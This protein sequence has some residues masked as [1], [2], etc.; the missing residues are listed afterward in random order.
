MQKA[1]H[2]LTPDALA[3]LQTIDQT[4]SFAAAARTLGMVPSALTYRVRQ[5]E[6][7][8]D[9]LLFDRS[10]RHARP[11][12]AGQ[13]LLREGTRLLEDIDAMANRVKRVATGWE[14][15][16]TLAVDSIIAKATVMELCQR[17]FEQAAPTRIRLRDETLSGTLEALTSGQADLA[18]GVADLLQTNTIATAPL[19]EVRFV[20]AVAPHHPLANAPEPLSDELL[21]QHRAVAVADNVS[22]GRGVTVGLLG[23]Q[24]V[25]TV[26]TMQAKLDAHLRGLG[27]GSLP[28]CMARDY[29]ESGRLVAKTTQAPVRTVSVK[30]AWRQGS[31]S[32]QAR[33]LQWWLAALQSPQTRSALLERHRG[34]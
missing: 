3:M 18:L 10:T 8:L 11:T 6:D 9:V 33:A 1:R 19:G 14:P 22:R 17:F 15:Q 30:Y 24:D 31:P 12:E 27:C 29:I 4:G 28:E 5:M 23:G 32:G 26:A 13:E 25:F 34:V 16:F 20:Y 7:A 2:I 21:R